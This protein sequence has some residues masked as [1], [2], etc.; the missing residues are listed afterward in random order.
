MLQQEE[1]VPE[2]NST[3]G[4]ET[5]AARP[6]PPELPE[7]KPEPEPQPEPEPEPQPKPKPDPKPEP[8]KPQVPGFSKELLAAVKNWTSVSPSVFPLK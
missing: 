8:S 1:P 4:N 7:P 3:D 2:S 6:L 5:A